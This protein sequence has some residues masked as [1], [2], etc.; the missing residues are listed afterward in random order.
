MFGFKGFALKLLL[1]GHLKFEDGKILALGEPICMLPLKYV[2]HATKFAM[3][4]HENIKEDKSLE[5][6][7]F[8]AWIA[9]YE[10]TKNMVRIYKLKKFEERYSVAMDAIS[11]FGFGDYKTLKF[12]RAQFAYFRVISNPLA[13]LF[14]P[15]KKKVD[16]FLSGANAGGGTI[17]HEVLINCVELDCAAINGK[18]CWFVNSNF[19]LFQK[20]KSK[21]KTYDI[22][23]DYII[24]K[25]MVYIKADKEYRKIIKLPSL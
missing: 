13:L 20:Y 21:G 1:G 15:T 16:I 12:K 3:M 7:Y 10:I 17:V 4:H 5:E 22:D 11:M 25:E 8:E 9:G 2:Y 19:E 23:W 24:K 14:H 18:Y 6:L